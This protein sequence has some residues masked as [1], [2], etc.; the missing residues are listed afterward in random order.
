MTTNDDMTPRQPDEN[1]QL[2]LVG[3]PLDLVDEI[4][5][6]ITDAD[7]YEHLRKV[8]SQSG[9]TGP[10]DLLRARAD[11]GDWSA[12]ISWPGCWPTAGTWTRPCRS[13]APAP[14]PATG[15]LPISWPGC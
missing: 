14:T 12:A 7:V 15:T 8:L 4:V 11:A 13:C 6:R 5:A 3:D 2:E 9:Y 10:L 1:E